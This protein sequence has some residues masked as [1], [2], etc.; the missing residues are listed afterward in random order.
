VKADMFT[1]QRLARRKFLPNNCPKSPPSVRYGVGAG[2]SAGDD[3]GAGLLL[4]IMP[5][6]VL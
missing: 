5:P 1:G 6:V 3:E 4:C 2:D